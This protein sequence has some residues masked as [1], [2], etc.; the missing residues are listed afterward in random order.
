MALVTGIPEPAEY[1]LDLDGRPARR[2]RGASTRADV[3]TSSIPGRAI[4]F[5]NFVVVHEKLFHA[6]IV[7]RDLSSS[8]TI[9]RSQE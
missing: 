9:I 7:S 5:T 1:R 2:R 6:F 3:C 8:C 4:R